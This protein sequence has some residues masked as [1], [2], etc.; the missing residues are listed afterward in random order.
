MFYIKSTHPALITIDKDYLLENE[1]DKIPIEEQD[2]IIKYYPL[3]KTI[4]DKIAIPYIVNI[5]K[6][7]VQNSN[8]YNVIKY[9]NQHT[10]IVLKPFLIT[11]TTF[12]EKKSYKIE[13]SKKTL[14]IYNHNTTNIILKDDN[15]HLY[16]TYP[17]P[18]NFIIAAE[19]D[20]ICH[21]LLQNNKH[22]YVQIN[23]EKVTIF[24]DIKNFSFDK[25]IFSA[26][27]PNHDMAKSG[28]AIEINFAKP[29]SCLT[30]EIYVNEAPNIITNNKLIPYAFLEAIKSKNYKLARQYM[31]QDMQDKLSDTSL[32]SFFNNVISISHDIYNDKV[33]TISSEKH[34]YLATDYDF[35]IKNGKICNII[36][37]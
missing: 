9:P 8:E 3:E 28:K 21:V 34:T 16:F 24:D 13:N 15:N 12:S 35:D 23:K 6:S 36:Q 20:N 25:N 27:L 10:E 33:C 19:I 22:I 7:L 37:L 31:S 14:D 2:I 29:Y 26:I 32:S 30:K 1:I 11:N 18:V 17:S 5:N 4:N